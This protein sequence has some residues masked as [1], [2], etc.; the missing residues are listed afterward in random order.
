MQ[1][2]LTHKG[3]THLSKKVINWFSPYYSVFRFSDNFFHVGNYFSLLKFSL[4]RMQTQIK[5]KESDQN[6]GV[7]QT[8]WK[9]QK[10]SVG[11]WYLFLLSLGHDVGS[12]GI[13]SSFGSRNGV[14]LDLHEDSFLP[15][16]VRL[17]RFPHTRRRRICG[18][19]II[20]LK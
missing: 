17:R 5:D 18:R 6:L 16:P 15:L 1:P 7:W 19:H 9:K 4:T 12:N 13:Q 10:D 11:E 20:C 8:K 14:A 3:R 2:I